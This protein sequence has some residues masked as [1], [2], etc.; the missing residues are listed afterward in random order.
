[1][2]IYA[3]DARVVAGLIVDH[4]RIDFFPPVRIGILEVTVLLWTPT[5]HPV[6]G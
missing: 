1:M 6:R 3:F 4:R 5:I 2:Y